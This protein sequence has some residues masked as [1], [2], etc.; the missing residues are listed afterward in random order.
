MSLSVGKPA[1]T[2]PRRSG[3]VGRP[4]GS[5]NVGRPRGSGNVGR[6]RRSDSVGSRKRKAPSMADYISDD[7]DKKPGKNI[8]LLFQCQIYCGN[9][10]LL[11]IC[12][13]FVLCS[14]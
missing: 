7:E 2:E 1:V 12:F 9:R 4:R 11:K 10:S 13:L 14:V 3:S 8:F 6:P 5:G